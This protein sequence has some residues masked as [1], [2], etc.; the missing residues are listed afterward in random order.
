VV[1]M[2]DRFARGGGGAHPRTERAL[3]CGQLVCSCLIASS[4]SFVHLFGL[5]L[6]SELD[7]WVVDNG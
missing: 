1:A 2:G 7:E 3:S 4:S 5:E 6:G